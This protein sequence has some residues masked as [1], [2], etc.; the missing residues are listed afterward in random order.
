MG[1]RSINPVVVAALLGSAVL[2]VFLQARFQA[3]NQWLGARIDLLPPLMVCLGLNAGLGVI[4][5]VS[6]AGGLLFDSLSANPLGISILPLLLIGMVVESIRD[7]IMKESWTAK[8][9]LGMAAGTWGFIASLA[10][11]LIFA[12]SPRQRPVLGIFTL[13]QG[14]V[15][16]VFSGLLAPLM[17]RCWDGFH[18][19][20]VFQPE[21]PASFREDRQI[22]RRHR[23]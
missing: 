6:L 20:F 18:Q 8:F 12:D 15:F 7:L 1:Y 10:I 13:W 2:T 11:L 21:N 4:A 9:T 22:V 17:C 5:S 16:A 23:G 14:I 3:P 19:A